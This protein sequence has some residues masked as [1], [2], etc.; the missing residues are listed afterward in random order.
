MRYLAKIQVYSPF[1]GKL[2]IGMMLVTKFFSVYFFNH[3]DSD[4]VL[5]LEVVPHETNR[6]IFDY[7]PHLRHR[8]TP[9]LRILITHPVAGG[10]K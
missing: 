10:Y 4:I 9:S 3:S 1:Q 7:F 8:I 6:L 2:I 5:K